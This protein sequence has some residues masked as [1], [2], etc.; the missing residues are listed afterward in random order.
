MGEW[1]EL[2]CTALHCGSG[3]AVCVCVCYSK[4]QRPTRQ[5]FFVRSLVRSNTGCSQSAFRLRQQQQQQ[6]TTNNQQQPTTNNND[7]IMKYNNT[8]Q[9]A[10]VKCLERKEEEET[11][12]SLTS[13]NIII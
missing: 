13:E 11:N 12:T 8:A 1:A 7:K 5:I 4:Q 3:V 10:K 9:K 6:P 2:M